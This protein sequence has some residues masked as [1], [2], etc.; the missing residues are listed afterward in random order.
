MSA[1]RV[2]F[3]RRDGVLVV[4]LPVDI[5]AANADGVGTE[6]TAQ[7]GNEMRGVVADLSC[8]R[9]LDSA[10]IDMIFR[11][12]DALK[13]RRQS[14]HLVLPEQ[15]PLTRVMR[16][17][18]M[19]EMVPIHENVDTAAQAIAAPGDERVQSG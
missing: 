7:L 1:A 8:T 9:F 3:E 14:L 11:L 19:S 4:G 13:M 10:G 5:D 2:L 17:V 6:V 18:Q 15:S 12:N 16:I